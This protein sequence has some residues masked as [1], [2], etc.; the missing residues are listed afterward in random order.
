MRVDSIVEGVLMAGAI[1][2]A[3]GA[4]KGG[5]GKSVVTVLIARQ[6]AAEGA[7]V[8]V[9]DLDPQRL[10]SSYRLGADITSPVPYSAVDLV[11]GPRKGG[12]P[13]QPMQ[14]TQNL[15]V[16]PANQRDLGSLERLLHEIH[17][18]RKLGLGPSPRRATLD[19][20]LTAEELNYDFV[21]LDTPTFFGEI[22]TN[23]L[24]AAHLVL[25]PV[26]MQAPDEAYSVLD[27]L[28]HMDELSRK[29]PVFFL[30]NRWDNGRKKDCGLAMARALELVPDRLLVD[31][32]L[33][34]SA[35]V[36]KA[37]DGHRDLDSSSDT[38]VLLKERVWKLTQKLLGRE[39]GLGLD[40][41]R[42][43]EG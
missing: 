1:R 32:I 21:L 40:L 9:V 43:G 26:N 25:S 18:E 24:E 31:V 8:L 14:V 6:L 36:A 33:P 10:S 41:F 27:L 17:E 5:V 34:A 11:K 37:M 3:I 16:V 39:P 22:T 15:D 4:R 2:V 13:F 23:A 42:A 7:R 20:R 29:P 38:A 30:P 35:E 28:E 19:S 12:R